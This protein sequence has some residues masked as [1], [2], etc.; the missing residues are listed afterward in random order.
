MQSWL[1]FL[2]PVAVVFSIFPLLLG[3]CSKRETVVDQATREG[4]MIVGNGVEP[5]VLDPQTNTGLAEG[6]ILDTLFEGLVRTDP[7][8]LEAIP[9][10]ATHWEVS[11][12]GL[13]YTFYLRHDASW[14]DGRAVTAHDFY[15]SYRRVLSVW[16]N[17]ENAEQFYPIAGAELYH[18]GKLR[19]F[20]QVGFRVIDDHTLELR[21]R[22]ATPLLPQLM[23]GRAWYPVPMHVL[24][25][26]GDPLAPGNPWTRRVETFV[27]N[28]P[29]KL[30]AWRRGEF[31]EVE[32]NPHYWGRD[33]VRLN[34]VRF[35]PISGEAEEAAFLSGKLHKTISVVLGRTERYAR[36]SPSP[37]RSSPASGIYFYL[38]NVKRAPFTDV[39]VRRALAMAV[40][41][42]KL[43]S[44]VTR[45]G[46]RPA[47]HLTL[48]EEGTGYSG[49]ARTRLDYDE[50]RRLLAEAGYAGGEGL[51]PIT[52]LYNINSG[53]HQSIAE[54]IAEDWRRELGIQVAL[55]GQEWAVFGERLRLQLF[56]LA[57]AGIIIEPYTPLR[58]LK[59]FTSTS[60]FNNTSWQ[61]ADYDRLAAEVE[62][63]DD[64]A[65]QNARMRRMEEIL[66]EEMP[67]IPIYYYTTQYLLHPSVKGWVD[68][69]SRRMPFERA[70]LE[71][72]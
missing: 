50:A 69:I 12:D 40:D 32:R 46:E 27:S 22:H 31:L 3:A 49:R 48:E 55:E 26:L 52:L 14:S 38:F 19:D 65:E 63:L 33:T 25:R 35:V 68:N 41:R 47:Y 16:T 60:A 44:E 17:S 64:E 66:M 70:W 9:G 30:K 59:T 10:V 71:A 2:G 51:R 53:W 42:E 34:G 72:R 36:E 7:E 29:F 39:R 58:F 28:G 5:A 57:R 24:E 61:N 20:T 54:S 62:L 45:S 43:V 67:M 18:K 21:L 37:L 56:Q 15:A 8:T 11:E 1:K 23:T 4:I 13:R 6:H